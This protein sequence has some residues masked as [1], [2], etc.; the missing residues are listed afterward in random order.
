MRF[1]LEIDNDWLPRRPRRYR[2]LFLSDLHLGSRGCQ[3]ERLV[4][5]LRG[6]EAEII[7]LVGDIVDGWRLGSKW[8]WPAAHNEILQILLR[9]ARR[10]V[11]IVYIPGN[12]DAFL[13]DFYGTHFGGVEV[14]ES[15]VHVAA[16]GRRYLVIHGDNF[17]AAL[18][19]TQRFAFLGGSV[20]RATSAIN[21]LLNFAR[22]CLGLSHWSL[23]Q[24]AKLKV[25]HATNYLSD[26]EQSLAELAHRH[27][28]DG[29]I[30]GHVHHAAIHDDL[31]IRYINCGDWIESCTAV[32]EH[33]NGAFELVSWQDRST[34]DG[35]AV[36]VSEARPA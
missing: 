27:E 14:V 6:H 33:G 23:S 34:H 4:D 20:V 3:S 17:D 30:C 8:Y 26:F 12:H 13:R 9:S 29:V 32:A 19:H 31:G 1:G 28:V 11:R 36:L 22:R 18:R 2:A 21:S 25:K 10:G 7:Y 16:D 15:A 35:R 24:W 5:F